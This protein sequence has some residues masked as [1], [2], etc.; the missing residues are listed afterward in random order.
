MSRVLHVTLLLILLISL[1]SSAQ[2]IDDIDWYIKT[3]IRQHLN[4]N[5]NGSRAAAMG[6]AFTAIADDATAMSWNSAGL[7]QL[8]SMEASVTGRLGVGSVTLDDYKINGYDDDSPNTE[9]RSNFQL[10]FLSFAIPFSVGQ[11]NIVGGIAFRRVY[12]FNF[13]ETRQVEV[14]KFTE[15]YTGGINAFTPAIGI[16]FNQIISAGLAL[17]IYTGS[18]KYS[19]IN[20]D[21][22]QYNSEY[23]E[24]T[25]FGASIDYGIIISPFPML[26]IGANLNLPYDL[27]ISVY[28]EDLELD[29]DVPFFYSIGAVIRATDQ[30]QFAVDYHSRS[31]SNSTYLEDEDNPDIFDLNSIHLGM[32]YLIMAGKVVIP[33]RAGFYTNPIMGSLAEFEGN[34]AVNKVLTFGTGI[35]LNRFVFDAAFELENSS[36]Y[37]EETRGSESDLYSFQ[38]KSNF[39]RMTLGATV[40]FGKL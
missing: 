23:N 19:Y 22:P 26:S 39:F 2:N 6:N 10:N 25:F 4:F 38:K 27:T 33:I 7:P 32:E 16:K 30:L 36:I 28:K 24:V 13:E 5:G 31:W 21:Y 3:F 29:V 8:Y 14:N 1:S 11:F 20:A 15:K 12:D 35:A 17:N 9:L 18:H 34:Q 40:H 37:T